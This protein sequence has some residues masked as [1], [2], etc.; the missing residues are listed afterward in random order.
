MKLVD[1]LEFEPFNRLRA[2]MGTR[3]LGYFELFD[4]RYHLTGAERIRLEQEGIGVSPW[5][6]QRLVDGTFAFKNS[7]VVCYLANQG[8]AAAGGDH[9]HLTDCSLLLQALASVDGQERPLMVSTAPSGALP[10]RVGNQQGVRPFKVCE[11]CLQKLG[12]EGFD[13]QRN[14]RRG[15]SL[16]LLDAFTPARFFARYRQYPVKP[17]E[18][19]QR[20]DAE[21][22]GS[23]GD[24]AQGSGGWWAHLSPP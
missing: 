18:F 8:T 14:R 5:Q 10:T 13:A 17:E 3:R 7:R 19:A 9:Y 22:A 6:V 12:F 4:P 21:G 20:V 23:E 24:D 11:Q 15:W 2:A 1:F 16:Q